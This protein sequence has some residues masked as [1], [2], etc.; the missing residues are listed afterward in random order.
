MAAWADWSSDDVG[1]SATRTC[2][3]G[4]SARAIEIRWRWPPDS[5]RSPDVACRSVMP[6]DFEQVERLLAGGRSSSPCVHWVHRLE[7]R[8]E[9]LLARIERAVRVLEDHLDLPAIGP[10]VARRLLAGDEVAVDADRAAGRCDEPDDGLGDRRL[11]AA[12]L[13]HDPG[14]LPGADRQVE[15]ADRHARRRPWSC[16]GRGGR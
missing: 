11:A 7:D 3:L 2:G 8:V 16:S 12:A 6:T 15:T 13:A 1:S 5:E 9:R 14:R 4:A 10:D